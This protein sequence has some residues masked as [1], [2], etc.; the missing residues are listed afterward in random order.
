MSADPLV[1]DGFVPDE[2]PTAAPADDGFI[3]DPE[4]EPAA[5]ASSA[6]GFRPGVPLTADFEAPT[7][8]T[9]WDAASPAG[10]APMSNYVAPSPEQ[11]AEQKAAE[12]ARI[13]LAF[14]TVA[15]TSPDE[16]TKV[17]GLAR[18]FG[19]KRDIIRTNL[20]AFEKTARA[21]AFDPDEWAKANPQL[22]RTLLEN[23][24]V[25]P[26][27]VNNVQ[28]S[29]LTKL[30]KAAGDLL[31]VE[32]YYRA[33]NPAPVHPG[34]DATPEQL[35]KYQADRL[36]YEDQVPT[37]VFPI[38]SVIPG[39]GLG[40]DGFAQTA[41]RL[42][43]TDKKVA[44][45]ADAETNATRNS[46]F[47]GVLIPAARFRE[48]MKQLELSRLQYQDMQAQLDGLDTT[49]LQGQ[50]YDLQLEMQP[51][52]F[53]EEGVTKVL[54][55]IVGNSASSIDV[56]KRAGIGSLVGM[57]LAGGATYAATRSTSA[58]QQAAKVGI[59]AGAT[60][61]A[62]D[63]SYVLETGSTWADSA[64]WRT[65]DGKP[66]T[67]GE[68]AVTAQLAGFVKTGI[69]IAELGVLLEGFGPGV[70]E[71]LKSNPEK[72][73]QLMRSDP[74][75]R[76]VAGRAAAAL[77]KAVAGE[78]AEESSQT[79][80][81]QAAQYIATGTQKGYVISNPN[82]VVDSAVAAGYGALGIGLIGPTVQLAGAMRTVDHAAKSAQQVPVILTMAAEKTAQA[83]PEAH[84]DLVERVTGE[85]GP[86]ATALH[87]D[88]I[89]T[90]RYFQ[91]QHGPDAEAKLVELLGPEAP[92]KLAE[93][94]ATGT[95]LEIPM[96]VVLEKWG[97]S[98]AAKALIPHTT[99]KADLLTPAELEAGAAARVEAEAKRIF[100]EYVAKATDDA[101]LSTTLDTMRQQLK[102][103]GRFSQ[104]EVTATMALWRAFLET[105]AKDTGLSHAELLKDLEVKFG[106]GDERT[107][108]TTQTDPVM[109]ALQAHLRGLKADARAR[110][111]YIDE[112]VSGLRTMRAW[113]ATPRTPGTQVAAVTLL[114][115]KAFNDNPAG[116]HDTTNEVLTAM[117]GVVGAADPKAARNGTNFVLEVPEGDAGQAAVN[118][119]INALKAK[120][121][122]GLSVVGGLGANAAA[123]QAN[124]DKVADEGRTAGIYAP[125]GGT[126]FNLANLSTTKFEGKPA[127][128]N[129]SPELL[130]AQ[131][132][133]AEHI[134]QA[135]F[136]P[137][138]PG[139]LSYAGFKAM[140]E[141][142]FVLS[143]DSK[144]LKNINIKFGKKGGDL[145]I[146]NLA[147]A[148]MA[149]GGK[150]LFFAHLSGDEFAAKSDSQEAL[151]Q[152][153][154]NL[155]AVLKA[156]E[157]YA[158]TETG[159]TE[160]LLVEFRSGIGEKTYGKADRKLNA[161]KQLERE[162][163]DARRIREAAGLEIRRAVDEPGRGGNL[164][165]PP[166][167]AERGGT[168]E[169]SGAGALQPGADQVQT[170]DRSGAASVGGRDG[171]SGGVEDTSFDPSTFEPAFEPQQM[172]DGRARVERMKSAAKKKLASEWLDFVE[173]KG[174]RP[175]VATEQQKTF[176]DIVKL[177]AAQ[178][179]LVDPEVGFTYGE[180]GR[181]LERSVGSRKKVA[182][183]PEALRKGNAS[184]PAEAMHPD[185]AARRLKQDATTHEEHPASKAG[186]HSPAAFAT[187]G[188]PEY[189]IAQDLLEQLG[190]QPV[191]QLSTAEIRRALQA[192][193]L[194]SNGETLNEELF[195]QKGYKLDTLFPGKKGARLRTLLYE[196]S[197]AI[198]EIE[199][200]N[201][202]VHRAKMNT[203]AND[204]ATQSGPLGFGPEY[205]DMMWKEV[206]AIVRHFLETGDRTLL[207]QLGEVA[208]K[209]YTDLP[210]EN[211]AKRVIGIF[212]NKSA[213]FSTLVHESAHAWLELQRDIANRPEADE[214]SKRIWADTQKFLGHES[215]RLTRE[216]HEKWARSFEA[217]MMEGKSPSKALASVFARALNWLTNIY[218]ALKGVPGG[219]L[220]DDGRR[221]FDALLA[222]DEA[223]ESYRKQTGPQTFAT[224]KAAGMTEE[225]FKAQQLERDTAS[226]EGSHRAALV[227]VKD[228]LRVHEAWWKAGVKKLTA[229]F[230]DE[231]EQLPARRAQLLLQGKLEGF[232]KEPVA[233]DRA[234]VEKIIGTSKFPGLKTVEEGGTRPA[235]VAEALGFPNATLML[236]QL[237]TLQQ[238]DTWVA[239]QVDATM[240]AM[241]PSVLNQRDVLQRLVAGGLHGVLEKQIL[242]D[243]ASLTKVAPNLGTMPVAAMKKAAAMI[244]ARREVG[245]LAP[246]SALSAER[247]AATTAAKAAAKGDRATAAKA[248]RERLLNAYLYRELLDAQD[249]R[250]SLE[251][252]AQT[253]GKSA[254]R[255][256]LGKAS[257]VYRDAV[258]F[259]LEG[260][261]FRDAKHDLDVGVLQQAVNQANGDAVLVGDPDWLE[262]LTTALR[263]TD[264]YRK[265][266]V[267][268]ADQLKDALLTLR[269]AAA[270]RNEVMDLTKKL[271]KAEVIANLVRDA[272]TNKKQTGAL[273][274]SESAAT[275][276]QTL[277][278][279][280][281]KITGPL[282]KIETMI[283]WLGG[284]LLG[285]DP[286][287]SSWYRS[288]FA[289]LEGARQREADLHKR[290]FEP[291]VQAF[292]EVPAS[293]RKSWMD[294]IDGAALFPSHAA[295]SGQLLTPPTKRFE[296]LMMALNA[297]N[298]GN[299]QRL[300]EGRNITEQQLRNA[301]S[302]LT[303]EEIA[304]VNT[305]GKA[306]ESM[307][308]EISAMEERITGVAPKAVEKQPFLLTNGVIEGHY[309]PAI[310]DRRVEAAGERQNENALAS[311][312]DPSYSGFGTA[313][314]HTKAR[315]DKFVGVIQLEPSAIM[316]HL[317]QAAHDLAYREAIMSVGRLILEPKVQVALKNALGEGRARQFKQWVKDAGTAP[318]VEGSVHAGMFMSVARKIRT[319]IMYS[320]LAY[321]VPNFIEDFSNIASAAFDRDLQAK[322]WAAGLAEFWKSPLA[323]IAEVEEKSGTMRAANESLKVDLTH[324]L[325]ELTARGPLN[326]GPMAFVKEHA[327]GLIEASFKAT[328]TPVWLGRYAQ[329]L[330]A[331]GTE[332]EAVTQADKIVRRLF[333]MHSAVNAAGIVRDKGFVGTAL[334]FYGFF[335]SA[336]NVML[337]S[338]QTLAEAPNKK[339][340]ARAAGR[341][342][343]YFLSISVIS[344]LL[345]GKGPDKDEPPDQWALRTMLG[346]GASLFPFGG[347]VGQSIEALIQGKRP[348]VRPSGFFS[349]VTQA[350]GQAALAAKDDP[351]AEKQIESAMRLAG[352]LTGIPTSQPLRTGKYLYD[353]GVGNIEPSDPGA[354]ISGL[355]YGE[356]SREPL[357]IPKAVGAIGRD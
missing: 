315:A 98:E 326:R 126:N 276:G 11:V 213:D 53:G 319:N 244:A 246:G 56:L 3:P 354:F 220:N 202:A 200:A 182:A 110:E 168:A 155:E 113:E 208:P 254:S 156:A 198:R 226:V 2:E 312:L 124:L 229:T 107:A 19:L 253:M 328:A 341:M 43:T 62:A 6:Q 314:S 5:P 205:G 152:F 330:E 165:S 139:V 241:H 334:Q 78:M 308:P 304:W 84:A 90:Q 176:D 44:Q 294:S 283:D 85:S 71:S 174:P 59:Q 339:D 58:A 93:A 109:A 162:G 80:V 242:E 172:A 337:D 127:E 111:L 115:A 318:G 15:D 40:V 32:R 108:E 324:R 34:A 225:E 275:L 323:K 67:V 41:S 316:T 302:M 331:G 159:T 60:Y 21:V 194:R 274:S 320:A 292:R 151:I 45:V 94:V 52:A 227:A 130:A 88:G 295:P 97:Q 258:D 298:L 104:K 216:Q 230:E 20:P 129:L 267:G 114:D 118:N 252:L 101:Q 271:D 293:V 325:N 195:V 173:G 102:D 191:S 125:R 72:I 278:A 169:A 106:I 16:E 117:G 193:W 99:T 136:D 170:E 256:R 228:A 243:W 77:G 273:P 322:H 148:A 154:Q 284:S 137:K 76:V 70:M 203:P 163:A 350:M 301:L 64:N 79:V 178:H 42:D 222:T 23:P 49:D 335:S 218:R 180:D 249:R 22:A 210:E 100:S 138:Y 277:S 261:G 144:G 24:E 10:Q 285:K 342:L 329:E 344:S 14:E 179:G 7:G 38:G 262:P 221:V 306:F 260:F 289:P 280:P 171:Q 340:K 212:L 30:L 236:S 89:E 150:E 327:F 231:Y 255:E 185:Q 352:P 181:S 121:P 35:K 164:Q 303:P 309:F 186:F 233:L 149:I 183:Q 248:M 353:I 250:E 223:T 351:D 33:T 199:D 313:H 184:S 141:R 307:W 47:S 237:A 66:L 266:E 224:A 37:S 215:G 160:R 69:E 65:D 17:L 143:A 297:G 290:I 333:P 188:T 31:D 145:A 128:H 8:V 336:L 161:A 68:R 207:Y 36:A 167:R 55:D 147:R 158:T 211:A 134:K 86:A 12:R 345:R 279:L 310:Y 245:K 39:M 204:A 300:T 219:D 132:T 321:S 343:G 75:F 291:I 83:A 356:S 166:Q 63:A 26:A 240:E 61:G 25:G 9:R 206:D 272:A 251:K 265:L 282:L 348:S 74:K 1:D 209:G 239:Q 317:V 135:Y 81:D 190:G 192:A 357:T 96:A 338:A 48:N 175:V 51:R 287:K 332:A 234:E 131:L 257:P 142:A 270:H 95:K 355:L 18:A 187:P 197:A 146:A 177:F 196:Q 133:D 232:G 91:E 57:T 29:A 46:S 299:L 281:G 214:R 123:A 87:V 120:L 73:A 54:S 349:V 346:T 119:L 28:A 4:P 27:I 259:L 263:T 157:L 201:S 217:Y 235:E 286:T 288:I 269:A 305:I 112:H 105:R 82:E 116:G 50:I 140:G 189:A 92:A 268:Q 103:T 153:Q 347:D 247:R 311:M 296:L 122:E 264:D 13:K 238:K